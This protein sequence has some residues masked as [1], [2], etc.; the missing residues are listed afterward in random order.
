[1]SQLIFNYGKL[2]IIILLEHGNAW[3]FNCKSISN[4][5]TP[6]YKVLSTISSALVT[7]H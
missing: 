2:G 7:I 4:S 3:S 5:K 6:V 1:M